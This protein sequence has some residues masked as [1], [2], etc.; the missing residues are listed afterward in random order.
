MEF[1][2]FVN[3][4]LRKFLPQ[5]WR[6]IPNDRLL[7]K[8]NL[9]I[10]FAFNSLN[11]D[12]LINILT[13]DSNFNV[14]DDTIDN[15]IKLRDYILS[16]NCMLIVVFKYKETK[17]SNDIA[18]FISDYI[19]I[20]HPNYL[21]LFCHEKFKMVTTI[22]GKKFE[23]LNVILK[24][25]WSNEIQFF[26][27]KTGKQIIN[28]EFMDDS[29]W[30]CNKKIKT[31]TGFVI[32]NMNLKYWDN[33][34]W[35]YFNQLISLASIPTKYIEQIKQKVSQLRESDYIYTP[36][37]YR[38][39]NTV[40]SKYWAATCPFCKSIRGSYFV[41]ESRSEYMHDLLSREIKTLEYH[42]IEVELNLEVFKLL[43]DGFEY[44]PHTCS[45]EWAK[46]N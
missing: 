45:T 36:I 7:G 33:R 44:C 16:K 30:K 3:I 40:K 20:S 17:E 26:G 5:D 31:L 1:K 21:T 15:A 13:I 9:K 41:D 27:P 28:L 39:S 35:R 25:I 42:S 18:H 8:D 6:M 22:D 32:P 12:K 10:S 46:V 38:Y 29:C 2:E 11:K 19:E 24:G 34:K 14:N 43:N 4:E 23:D 37:E